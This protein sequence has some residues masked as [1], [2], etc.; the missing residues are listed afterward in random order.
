MRKLPQSFWLWGLLLLVLALAGGRIWISGGDSATAPSV[1]AGG[2]NQAIAAADTAEPPPHATPEA[3]QSAATEESAL[4]PSLPPLPAA[5]APHRAPAA[6]RQ[7]DRQRWREEPNLNAYAAELQSRAN[8]GDA[9][10]AMTLSD[11]YGLCG[12]A[13]EWGGDKTDFSA[14]ELDMQARLGFSAAQTQQWKS[15]LLIQ[16][17]RCTQWRSQSA[18]EWSNSS[19][20]WQARAAQLEHPGAFFASLDQ[21]MDSAPAEVLAQARPYALELLRQRDL[22][23][24]L[25]YA[26]QLA[27]LT[28]YDSLGFVMAACLLNVACAP[29]PAAYA[30]SRIAAADIMGASAYG[31]LIYAG[32]RAQLIAQR[33][34][35]EIAALWRAGRFD[36]ILSGRA[37]G[38]PGGG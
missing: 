28:P 26:D 17:Q 33:Q 27:P 14:H 4:Q 5:I 8:A 23:E 2:A 32:P 18:E 36:L 16:G 29:D 12:M 37:S 9:D 15:F 38:R 7:Q 10:A 25:R 35:E 6:L 19:R 30:D 34:A 13:A 21:I 20:A 22:D 31:P 24:M 1:V 3:Q 11:L